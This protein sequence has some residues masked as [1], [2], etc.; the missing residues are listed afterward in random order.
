MSQWSQVFQVNLKL[1]F[2]IRQT[3]RAV[4]ERSTRL[5]FSFPLSDHHNHDHADD[6]NYDADDNNHQADHH[7]HDQADDDNYR[8]VPNG[9]HP[10]VED[11]AS[12]QHRRHVPRVLFYLFNLV[13]KHFNLSNTNQNKPYL[14]K[15]TD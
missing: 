9:L 8:S 13:F 11:C 6:H 12:A 3:Y 14:T 7:N 10:A 5:S 1:L 15:L 2:A 4:W